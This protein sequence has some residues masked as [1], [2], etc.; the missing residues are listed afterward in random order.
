MYFADVQKAEIASLLS[1]EPAFVI[2]STE[3]DTSASATRQ[4]ASVMVNVAIS[5]PLS[6]VQAIAA[7]HNNTA[8]I[9]SLG[10]LIVV[11]RSKLKISPFTNGVLALNLTVYV[12]CAPF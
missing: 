5:F 12:V 4:S 7:R 6:A 2:P 11:G 1:C 8:Q 3:K 10:D 9:G